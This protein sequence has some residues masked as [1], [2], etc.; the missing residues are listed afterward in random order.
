E[1]MLDRWR[2]LAL[3]AAF[4][5]ALAIGMGGWGT[6]IERSLR[7]LL[8]QLHGQSAS[9]DLHIVEI[10]ARSIGA[11][12]RW[13]WPRGYHARLI[14]RL[15]QAGAAS[16]AF[17]V[18]FS[19]RSTAQEDRALAS[20]LERARGKVILP[21]FRQVAGGGRDGWI[22]SLPIAG[23][24]AHSMA[25]SVSILPDDDG[26]VRRMPI[27]AITDGVPRPP[28]SAIIA[29]RGGRAGADF[30]IDFSISPASVPRHSFLDILDGRFEPT[31]FAGKHVLVGATAVEMG[32]RYVV[33]LHGIQP[34]VVV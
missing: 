19:S 6:G 33:P 15:Y 17:D 31:P 27:G 29:G 14:D 4:A 25:A 23:L 10:D 28:L 22:D 34:G 11:I 5:L 21:T 26:Y 7:S 16:I 24:R 3:L 2:T 8:W 20:A 18:D 1:Q 32:D 9:G 12:D 30:P 13:P